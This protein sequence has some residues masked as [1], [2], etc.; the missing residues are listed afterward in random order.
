MKKEPERESQL[1]QEER[2]II[3]ERRASL[4]RAEQDKRQDQRRRNCTMCGHKMEPSQK[5]L[6]GAPGMKFPALVCPNC[7]NFKFLETV[8]T[9]AA[10][11]VL[12]EPVIKK[13]L[14]Q[15]GNFAV[16][17]PRKMTDAMGIA[18]NHE[19]EIKPEGLNKI[20]LYFKTDEEIPEEV[21][22]KI[23]KAKH[24]SEGEKK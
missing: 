6:D 15:G 5:E 21:N 14:R 22:E 16:V 17:L 10:K 8:A 18:L 13:I 7:G 19:V 1:T 23:T 9:R 4:K 2:R 3:E 12:I 20:S 11:I 24:P